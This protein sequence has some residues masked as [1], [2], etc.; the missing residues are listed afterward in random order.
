[1]GVPRKQ[2]A[3]HTLRR[4]AL[5]RVPQGSRGWLVV[6]RRR[7]RRGRRVGGPSARAVAA[8]YLLKLDAS[9]ELIMAQ[10]RSPFCSGRYVPMRLEA[11]SQGNL[12]RIQI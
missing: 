11:P 12:A 7:G 6:D 4:S 3:E 5:G 10:A 9:F 1:M 2:R 8:A